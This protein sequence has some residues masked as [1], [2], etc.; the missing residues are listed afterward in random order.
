VSK[1]NYVKQLSVQYKE[2]T[3]H[4]E[5]PNNQDQLRTEFAKELEWFNKQTDAA[6]ID[7]IKDKSPKKVVR[8]LLR[9]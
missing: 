6:V 1:E 3:G 2:R 7:M 4:L 9:R 8:I 5:D